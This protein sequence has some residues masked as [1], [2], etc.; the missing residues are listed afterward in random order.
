MNS[1]KV[2]ISHSEKDRTIAEKILYYLCSALQIE[3]EEI[4]CTSVP[5]HTLKHGKLPELIK[6]DISSNPIII[7]ILTPNSLKST[8]VMFELGASWIK[9]LTIIPMIAP[10]LSYK[11]IPDPLKG[12]TSIEFRKNTIAPQLTEMVSQISNEKNIKLKITGKTDIEK[13]RLIDEFKNCY[14]STKSLP[15]LD[16]KEL[17]ILGNIISLR[18]TDVDS[19]LKN[20]VEKMS[21]ETNGIVLA[22][23]MQLESKQLVG[24][25]LKEGTRSPDLNTIFY[26]PTP[27]F[28]L[29]KGETEIIESMFVS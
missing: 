23:L 27:T 21:N 8:W 28:L 13:Q 6:N 4:R 11:N 29:I 14:S 22:Y 10:P 18:A 25:I 7:W 17:K 9:G 19:S 15:T 3:D 5:G 20:I 24:Y 16:S 2:F 26:I 1:V 12:L